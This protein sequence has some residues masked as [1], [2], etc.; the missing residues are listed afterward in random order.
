M[1]STLVSAYIN[2]KDK[3]D[4]QFDTYKPWITRFL[5]NNVQKI[6]FVDE[7]L[8]H[9]FEAYQNEKTLIVKTN[10]SELFLAPFKNC[11][12]CHPITSN[13]NK[14]N[15][16]F[17]ALM[18]NKTEYVRRA[19]EINHFGTTNFVWVD[20]G[21]YHILSPDTNLSALDK[22]YEKVRIAGIW[23]LSTPPNQILRNIHW[24]FCGT[25]F[26]GDAKHLIEFADRQKEECLKL[27]QEEGTLTWEVNVWYLVA[28]KSR[29]LFDIYIA[30]HNTSIVTKY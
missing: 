17:F 20:A 11:V 24:Y 18:C 9:E 29:Q 26:G 2:L 22:T 7:S 15:F 19:I 13:P 8:F 5:Q 30:D 21:V 3:R 4:K 14:D 1:Q 6:F 28:L 25:I 10:Y 23:D 27:V 12:E 16:D